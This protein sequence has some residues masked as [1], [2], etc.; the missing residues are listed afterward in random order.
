MRQMV[1]SLQSVNQKLAHNYLDY[2]A[3]YLVEVTLYGLQ[4]L[5][6]HKTDSRLTEVAT[7]IAE[8]QEQHLHTNLKAM[9]HLIQSPAD[10]TV[11]AGTDKPET[12][13]IIF[14]V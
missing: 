6:L 11:I 13:C 1:P 8:A 5:S 9:S 3:I 12:V 4:S 7:T 2:S 14:L 10:V